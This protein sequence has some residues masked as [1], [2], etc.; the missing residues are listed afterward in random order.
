LTAPLD[1]PI[2]VVKKP[3]VDLAVVLAGDL[4]TRRSA[5]F[6]KNKD[7][8]FAVKVNI[9]LNFFDLALLVIVGPTIHFT[10]VV[11]VLLLACD[12]ASVVIKKA[13]DRLLL[14]VGG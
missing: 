12:A 11:G 8:G 1:F 10:I 13:R 4:L 2:G 14:T 6:I 7:I 3:S 5:R 9:L